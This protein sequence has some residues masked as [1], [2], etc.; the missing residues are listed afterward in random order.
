[1]KEYIAYRDVDPE[2][3]AWSEN[4]FLFK[5]EEDAA[6]FFRE[7]NPDLINIY[8]DEDDRK[9]FNFEVLRSNSGRISSISFNTEY[10]GEVMI[11]EMYGGY[12]I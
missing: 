8:T 10:A 3:D 12:L 1:M 2:H 7:D 9:I 5:S 4:C 11:V 6:N